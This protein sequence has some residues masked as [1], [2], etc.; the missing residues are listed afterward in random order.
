MS[1]QASVLLHH[2]KVQCVLLIG[3]RAFLSGTC[4]KEE[5]LFPK[6]VVDAHAL[7]VGGKSGMT[8]NKS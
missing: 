1:T 2:V 8:F 4:S 6:F 3:S 7:S 5:R